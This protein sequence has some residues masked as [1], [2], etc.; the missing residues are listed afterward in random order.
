MTNQQLLADFEKAIALT[1][2][3]V[4]VLLSSRQ[5]RDTFTEDR[6]ILNSADLA[7]MMMCYGA[8][9]AFANYE[10]WEVWRDQAVK[11]PKTRAAFDAR[12]PKT[13]PQA[14]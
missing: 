7:V 1:D 13:V 6:M 14:A 12:H 5:G 3:T 9:S 4:S 10:E 2:N 11:L 8:R